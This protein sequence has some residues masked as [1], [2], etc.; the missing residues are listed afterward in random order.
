MDQQDKVLEESDESDTDQQQTNPILSTPSNKPALMSKRDKGKKTY[1]LEQALQ[2]KE[3]V[4]EPTLS[5]SSLKCLVLI[6][7]FNLD[8]KNKILK[9]TF[10]PEFLIMR[11]IFMILGE[12]VL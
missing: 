1:R 11:N 7:H 10:R 4:G 8:V 5:L 6:K 2:E 3:T 9:H 12:H